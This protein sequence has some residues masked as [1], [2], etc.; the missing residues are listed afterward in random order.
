MTTIPGGWFQPLWKIWKS[1]GMII[2]NIWKNKT[3]SKPPTS[4]YLIYWTMHKHACTFKHVKTRKNNFPISGIVSGL[5]SSPTRIRAAPKV[6]SLSG[7]LNS[8]HLLLKGKHQLELNLN[9]SWTLCNAAQITKFP[10]VEGV[11]E[12][13]SRGTPWINSY[14]PVSDF[15]SIWYHDIQTETESVVHLNMWWPI[16]ES[17]KLLEW[18]EYS[19]RGMYAQEQYWGYEPSTMC[20]IWCFTAVKTI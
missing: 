18:H 10:T 19:F 8:A 1:V 9:L 11:Q 16:S 6:I 15:N 2:P 17:T 14:F 20:R 13:N 7:V 3:C 4:N 5:L 12:N